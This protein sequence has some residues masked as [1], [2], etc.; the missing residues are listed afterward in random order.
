LDGASCNVYDANL[1][2]ESGG[3]KGEPEGDE[4]RQD[5]MQQHKSSF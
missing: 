1:Q 2:E 4:R 3:G 5:R